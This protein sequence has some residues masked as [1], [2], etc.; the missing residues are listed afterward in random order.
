MIPLS[1]IRYAPQEIE[2]KREK[3]RELLLQRSQNI[4]N[5]TISRIS[6]DD[7][8][9]L[10]DLY[11]EF[12]LNSYFRDYYRGKCSFSLSTRMTRAAA[13]LIYPRDLPAIREEQW[14]IEIRVGVDFF[15]GYNQ[16]NRDKEVAGIL[17][18]DA[19]DAFQIAFEHEIC[20]FIELILYRKTSC[21]QE[22]FKKIARDIFG[23]RKSSHDLPT[24]R[25]I[26]YREYGLKVGDM[27]TFVIDGVSKKGFING[28][29]KRATIMVRDPKG[30][31]S[32]RTGI[33]Y[34]KYYVP[35]SLLTPAQKI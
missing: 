6:R 32:D 13:K 35:I 5:D 3:V 18:R 34:T 22:S 9:I 7:L 33:R 15:F 11:D 25:E 8:K 31:F 16:I 30:R 26:A 10:F 24:N 14:R 23:H 4:K 27:V 17:T 2:S 21:R 20:H 28:I 12:F 29:N 1:D 19:L